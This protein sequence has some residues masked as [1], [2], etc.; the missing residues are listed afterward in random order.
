MGEAKRRG[1]RDQR[2]VAAIEERWA[3][4]VEAARETAEAEERAERR[5][6][7]RWAAIPGS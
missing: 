7:E 6:A 5:R 4:E 1:S 2:V 3:I